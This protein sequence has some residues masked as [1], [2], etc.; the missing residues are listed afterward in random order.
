MAQYIWPY[1]GDFSWHL[2]GHS[3]GSANNLNPQEI[4][5]GKCLD[6]GV[7]NALKYNR[8]PFFSYSEIKQIMDRKSLQKRDH[9]SAPQNP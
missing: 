6:I 2:M 4:N 1:Q 7:D 8:T 3:H 5:N 9:H